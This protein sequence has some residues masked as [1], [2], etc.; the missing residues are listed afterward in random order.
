ML[1]GEGRRSICRQD[2]SKSFWPSGST[3]AR[4]V[5]SVSRPRPRERDPLQAS[6]LPRARPEAE[7]PMGVRLGSTRG[8]CTD[9]AADLLS[10]LSVRRR[11]W[12]PSIISTAQCC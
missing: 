1:P 11:S 10:A 2:R 3:L 9:R 6:L 7:R 12:L 8:P 5:V 4:V